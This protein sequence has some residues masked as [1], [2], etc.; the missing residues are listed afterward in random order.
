MRTRVFFTVLLYVL[1]LSSLSAQKSSN[2]ITITGNVLYEDGRPVVNGIVMVDGV[3]TNSMTDSKGAYKIKVRRTAEK[4][5]IIS[6][7][8]GL[9]EEAIAGRTVINF[10]YSTSSLLQKT[11]KTGLKRD[12]GLN[13]GYNYEK[14]KDMTTPAV[15]IDGNDKKYAAYRTVSEIITREYAGV[16]YTGS[17]YVI[18]GSKDLFGSVPALLIVD[19]V[20]VDNF[21]GISPST[22]ESI[23]I[24]KGSSASIYG[25]RGYGGAILITTKKGNE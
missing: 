21:D 16:N 8:S 23:T 4:V 25:A 6:L 9:I 5:G 1:I 22:V 24:L 7:T 11:D 20:N 17:S 13:T 3:N 19:G 12:E 15:R 2:K 10:K 14:E 18:Q